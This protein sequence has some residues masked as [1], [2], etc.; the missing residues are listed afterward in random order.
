MKRFRWNVGYKEIFRRFF[1][2]H[3]I[4]L[5]SNEYFSYASQ[6]NKH[7]FCSKVKSLDVYLFGSSNFNLFLIQSSEH[8]QKTETV[9]F[10]GFSFWLFS[11]P[12]SVFFSISNIRMFCVFSFNLTTACDC[13]NQFFSQHYFTMS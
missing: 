9:F 5:F 11:R 1:V 12:R 4:H 6:W 8:K 7:Y 10:F 3:T 13:A 2:A